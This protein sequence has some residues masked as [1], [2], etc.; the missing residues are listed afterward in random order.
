M[1]NDKV[2]KWCKS[3]KEKLSF[4]I[5]SRLKIV[6]CVSPKFITICRTFDRVQVTKFIIVKCLDLPPIMS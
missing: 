5:F 6:S 3:N 1:I 4:T 2:S